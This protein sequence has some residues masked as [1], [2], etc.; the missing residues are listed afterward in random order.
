LLQKIKQLLKAVDAHP[1]VVH[2][3]NLKSDMDW[4][5]G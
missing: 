3:G 1:A 5:V 4:T 2:Q